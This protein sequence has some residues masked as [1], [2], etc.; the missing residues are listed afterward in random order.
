[1]WKEVKIDRWEGQIEIRIPQ[2]ARI[3]QSEAR[4]EEGYNPTLRIRN[5]LKN[6][7]GMEPIGKLVN[8]ASKVAVA[9]DNPIKVC[10]SA[11]T[12]PIVLEELR[13]AG[14]K[15]E[16]IVLVSANGN[17]RK[18]TPTEFFDYGRRGYGLP[19][20]KG[21]VAVPR[22]IFEEFWPHRFI[23]NDAAD[24]N[25]LI[26]MGFSELGDVV[27]VNR[28][29]ADYDLVIYTGGVFPM[30]WG[31]YGGTGV[32]IGLGSARS[33]ASHHTVKVIGH[34]D[35]CHGNPSNHYFRR[36]KDAIMKRIE[37]YIGRKVFYIEGA[38][39]GARQW[40]DFAAGHFKE[41]QGP[42]W[43]AADKDR[44]YQVDQADVVVLGV[45][46]WALY[47]TSRNPL[48]CINSAAAI[49]RNCLEKP[50]LREGGVM[51][52]V[53]VCD[54][55]IDTDALPSYPEVID[56]YGKMGNANRLEEKYLEEF[57]YHRPEYL[58]K[59]MA[60]NAN[61]PVHP[62]WLFAETQFLQDHVGK[63][64]IATAEYPEA[65]RKLGAA[66][67][68]D[69]D[70]AWKMAEQIVGK[71]PDTVVLPNFFTNAPL[72]FGVK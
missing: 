10:P 41:I 71:N 3:I 40:T 55:T 36:H 63:L 5:A 30:A 28:V 22:E 68:G 13:K 38:L 39:N 62:F 15:E 27:E 43:K 48:M 67:A 44:I 59:H 54:G 33:V 46:K 34:K 35:A 1:V 64:I 61:H 52:V 50:L 51:I 24:P 4:A 19:P 37:E 31:G 56:L 16:N 57:L 72:K 23:R 6:P 17:Q 65:A 66:W 2:S 42:I 11:L 47:D 49:L 60:G 9:F 18:H 25:K 53:A 14:V 8:K 12:I 7:L 32:A 69:F 45:P 29:V 21:T 70:Q 26:N 20:G 58:R